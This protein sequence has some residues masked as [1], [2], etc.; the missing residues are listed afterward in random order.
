MYIFYLKHFNKFLIPKITAYFFFKLIISIKKLSEFG[1]I[2][3]G[4]L[5]I[6]I[7]YDNKF[8]ITRSS[9]DKFNIKATRINSN[10]LISNKIN[11]SLLIFDLNSTSLSE[12]IN[13]YEY[14]SKTNSFRIIVPNTN[15]CIG[16]DYAERKGQIIRF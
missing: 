5:G 12:I 13:H 1:N 14:L 11:N 10:Y 8:L 9:N 15:F 7:N 4:V 16:S 6:K 3:F 2:S